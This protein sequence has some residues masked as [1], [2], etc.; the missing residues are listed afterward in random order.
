MG[1]DRGPLGLG[2]LKSAIA[3]GLRLSHD[4]NTS[5]NGLIHNTSKARNM[6][7]IDETH[8]SREEKF[9]RIIKYHLGVLRSNPNDEVRERVYENGAEAWRMRPPTES[10]SK[11]VIQRKNRQAAIFKEA[12]GGG[13]SGRAAFVQFRSMCES[14]ERIMGDPAKSV[15]RRLMV[16]DLYSSIVRL[17]E[18]ERR[19][20]AREHM[21]AER[22]DEGGEQEA[23]RKEAAKAAAEQ[24][25]SQAGSEGA[26]ASVDGGDDSSGGGSSGGG[27]GGAN[28]GRNSGQGGLPEHLVGKSVNTLSLA[29]RHIV[30]RHQLE[31]ILMQINTCK[32][33]AQRE[34]LLQYYKSTNNDYI[35]SCF[36]SEGH[37]ELEEERKTRMTNPPAARVAMDD[38]SVVIPREVEPSQQGRGFE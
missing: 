38:Q 1:P 18:E 29:D 15:E 9:G 27:S 14:F 3:D 32:N 26:G 23:L 4:E 5:I 35:K 2:K 28:R 36:G 22:D 20:D 6:C 16:A 13:E 30:Y 37:F 17:G 8:G 12:F 7:S 10:E 11:G 21:A 34:A 31:R 25:R 19:V 24:A 33:D